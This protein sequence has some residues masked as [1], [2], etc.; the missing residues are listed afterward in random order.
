VPETQ[1][2]ELPLAQ[3]EVDPDNVRSEYDP[4]IVAGLRNAL[5]VDGSFINAP[6]VYPI[7]KG[8]YRV[9]HG[10]TR[11]LAAQGVLDS[12]RVRVVDPPPSESTKLL[13]Q[14]GENLLQGSLRPAD[15]GVALKR[16]RD[17]DGKQRSLSQLVGALKAAGLD[18][19]KSWVA[20]HLALA[21]LD[22]DV[23][24]LINQGKIGAE[25]A[26]QLRGLAHEDQRAWAERIISEGITLAELRRLLGSTGPDESALVPAEWINRQVSERFAQ[27]AAGYVEDGGANGRRVGA[28][29]QRR[30]GRVMSRWEL[31]PVVIE[32]D[33]PHRLRPLQTAEWAREASMIEKQ[34][35]QE[36]MFMGGY[37]AGDAV[38]LVVQAVDEAE[39]ASETVMAAL[40]A[41]R[42]LV[43]RPGD[44]RPG[45]A[46]AEFMSMRMNR[47]LA[48]LGQR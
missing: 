6:L 9:K 19:T 22:R 11:V 47:V 34:L 46:L 7:D 26:Y 12:M 38:N 23:Q 18:R 27:A 2:L 39:T 13:S 45:S 3:I 28:E 20:M 25:V 31:L 43:D 15:I 10:S 5:R 29:G 40:N 4:E 24:R 41:V 35:A 48:N 1:E 8:R 42:Q 14:M 36:A 30:H 32:A 37:A 44:L 21:D 17:A 16:L 33:D